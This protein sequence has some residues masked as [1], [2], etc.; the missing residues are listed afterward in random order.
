MKNG[1]CVTCIGDSVYTA[2]GNIVVTASAPPV[3]TSSRE[4]HNFLLKYLF[5]GSKI[6]GPR[7]EKD[8]DNPGC[9]KHRPS[10]YHCTYFFSSQPKGTGGLTLTFSFPEQRTLAKLA[11]LR[12]LIHR[13]MPIRLAKP[14]CLDFSRISLDSV[15]NAWLRD[16]SILL[17][18]QLNESCGGVVI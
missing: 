6:T 16:R 11:D 10:K 3:K 5:D 15:R 2:P 9:L 12:I 4:K 14:G 13:F 17:C 7:Y 8:Y 18:N 1:I